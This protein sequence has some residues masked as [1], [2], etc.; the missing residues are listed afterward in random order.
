MLYLTPHTYVHIMT[1]RRQRF[2]L[3]LKALHH[4]PREVCRWSMNAWKEQQID[5]NRLNDDHLQRM[6]STHLLNISFLI[7]E[8]IKETQNNR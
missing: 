6:S 3:W 1:I 5:L 2:L 8:S 7:S 4:C